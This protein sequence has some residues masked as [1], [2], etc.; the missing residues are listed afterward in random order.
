MNYYLTPQMSVFGRV[1]SGYQF[2]QFDSLRSAQ[3]QITEI[4]QYELGLKTNTRL[5]SAFLTG[6]YNTFTGLSFQQIL[7]N[8]QTVNSIGGSVSK[9]LEAELAVRPL[10]GLELALSG[11]VLDAT[12]EDFGEN[13]GNR[14]QRQ[15]KVQFRFTP[16]AKAGRQ[17]AGGIEPR[18][19][20]LRALPLVGRGDSIDER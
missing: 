8:G 5:Y 16:R 7:A 17:V 19:L 18:V 1:N 12:Y 15:P 4:K 13:T 10:D 20:S 6:F 9:G 3:T 11:N 2:P 14:V